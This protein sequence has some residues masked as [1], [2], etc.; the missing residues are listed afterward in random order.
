MVMRLS[1]S[2]AARG[3]EEEEEENGRERRNKFTHFT[4][5]SIVASIIFAETEKLASVRKS[6]LLFWWRFSFTMFRIKLIA[7]S[8]TLWNKNQIFVFF[9]EV[10][11]TI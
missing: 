1:G 10:P 2:A 7:F 8:L 5:R 4:T 3:G 6:S 11:E 9:K